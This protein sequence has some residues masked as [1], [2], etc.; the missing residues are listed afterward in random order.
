[1]TIPRC[2]EDLDT[3]IG[4]IGIAVWLGTSRTS[5][6]RLMRSG[7]FG[8][9]EDIAPEGARRAQLRVRRSGVQAWLDSRQLEAS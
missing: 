1:M 3:R 2:D 7:A 4:S 5:A 8:N 9:P 6:W